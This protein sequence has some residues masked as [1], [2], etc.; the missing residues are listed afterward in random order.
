MSQV[1]IVR[2]KEKKPDN[3]IPGPLAEEK[4]ISSYFILLLSQN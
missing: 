1:P 2:L 4:V 3:L